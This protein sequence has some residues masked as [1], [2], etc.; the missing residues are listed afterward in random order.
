MGHLYTT[1]QRNSFT[2]TDTSRA[3]FNDFNINIGFDEFAGLGQV[4]RKRW[5]IIQYSDASQTEVI[6]MGLCSSCDIVGIGLYDGMC[7][8]IVRRSSYVKFP[9]ANIVKIYTPKA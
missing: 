7:S 9:S 4:L 2:K 5:L 3:A 1:P 8:A 6:F